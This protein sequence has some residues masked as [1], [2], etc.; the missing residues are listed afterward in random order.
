MAKE[1]N[2]GSYEVNIVCDDQDGLALAD[3]TKTLSLLHEKFDYSYLEAM[4][5][6]INGFELGKSFDLEDN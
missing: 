3:I 5:I 1:I 6:L 4:K 2:L